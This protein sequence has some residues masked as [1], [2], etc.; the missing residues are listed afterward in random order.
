MENF[1]QIPECDL[2]LTK[3][4]EI[5]K[6]YKIVDLIDKVENKADSDSKTIQK[7][8]FKKCI[9]IDYQNE[10]EPIIRKI[11]KLCPVDY[12]TTTKSTTGELIEIETAEVLESVN[13]DSHECQL[14][15]KNTKQV[16]FNNSSIVFHIYQIYLKMDVYQ[17][18]QS[19]QKKKKTN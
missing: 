9:D 11:T 15:N 12:F 2:L 6:E 5:E 10:Q 7:M 19:V 17:R 16:I 3:W 4:F 8:L 18:I 13:I 1:K 14:I